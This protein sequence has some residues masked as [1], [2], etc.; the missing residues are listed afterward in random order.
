VS[1]A[2]G[3]RALLLA[4]AVLVAAP[5]CG[6][7]FASPRECLDSLVSAAATGDGARLAAAHD[8][9]T[10]AHR[11]QKILELR[12]LLARGDAPE[13]TLGGTNFSVADVTT[14]TPDDAVG[15]LFVL[16]S[17][18]VREASWYASAKVIEEKAEGADAA[19]L[20]VRGADGRE[21]DLWFVREDGRWTFDYERTWRR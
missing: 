10:R 12:A 15:R 3:V 13:D 2:R 6:G 7:G 9:E 5:S 17:P 21:R 18:F 19:M 14:G 4:I 11:R 8:A 1:A 16:H 20:R